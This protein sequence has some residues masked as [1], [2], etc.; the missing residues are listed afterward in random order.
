M[1][2]KHVRRCSVSLDIREREIKYTVRSLHTH[3]SGC[4][5]KGRNNKRFWA[6]GMS[7]TFVHCWQKCNI[8]QPLREAVWWF[9]KECITEFPDVP[10]ILLLNMYLREMKTYA[11]TRTSLQKFTAALFTITQMWKQPECPLV[12]GR[13]NECRAYIR[14]MEYY[15]VRKRS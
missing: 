13:V 9:P 15:S 7:K 4:H 14:T 3:Y 6:C 8:V 10:L 11:Q 1:A 2:S 12:G 5:Q